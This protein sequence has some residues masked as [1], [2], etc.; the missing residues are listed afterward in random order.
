MWPAE[1]S[2][3]ITISRILWVFDILPGLD[4]NGNDIKPDTEAYEPGLSLTSPKPF[5][6][7]FVM[8]NEEKRRMIIDEWNQ[9]Q[10]EGYKI[11]GDKVRIA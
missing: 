4:E 5:K 9:A 8:R 2:L 1:N 6:A 10:N 11:L 3:F 7:R